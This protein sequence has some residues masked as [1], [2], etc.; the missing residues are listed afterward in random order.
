MLHSVRGDKQDIFRDGD[1]Q[2]VSYERDE[3]AMF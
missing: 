2:T 1:K 3:Q